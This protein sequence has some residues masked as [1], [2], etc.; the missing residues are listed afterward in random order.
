MTNIRDLKPARIKGPGDIIIRYLDSLGWNQEDLAEITNVSVKTISQIINHKQSISIEMAKMLSKAFNNNPEF[1]LN[2][3][4]QYRLQLVNMDSKEDCAA[5]KAK[6]RKY[7][8]VLEIQ[9]NKWVSISDKTA[10]GY[11]AT[12]REIWGTDY[13][14]ISVYEKAPQYAA[15]QKK[16]DKDY[17]RFY[18]LTWYKIAQNRVKRIS[19]PSYDRSKLE[20]IQKEFST[21]TLLPDGINVLVDALNKAGVKFL[22]QKHLQRTYL[23]GACFFDGDNPVIVYTG[24]YDRSDHFWFT[25]AHEISHILLH[26]G[27]KDSTYILDNFEDEEEDMREKEANDT[28]GNMLQYDKILTLGK[29]FANYFSERKLFEISSKVGVDPSIVIGKLQ[30][31]HIISYKSRL[32]RYKQKIRDQ[33]FSVDGDTSNS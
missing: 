23:D 24:R 28:A 30:H 21:F 3:D 6:I 19:I 2:L 1:W 31:D 17:T 32:N 25:I 33:Y 11:K 15:R 18:S 8:P 29:P 20:E 13:T 10:N 12:F 7:M 26:F 27:K 16:E 9:K 5:I 22:Y 4:N 14:D